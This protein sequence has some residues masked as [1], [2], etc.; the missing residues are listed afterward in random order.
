M[1]TAS[2]IAFRAY[3]RVI[4][5]LA[6]YPTLIAFAFFGLCVLSMAMEYQ[7]WVMEIKQQVDIGLVRNAENARLILG[8]LVAGIISLMVFSFSM[9]MVVLNNAAAALSPRV[10]PGLISSKGHQ[11]TLGLY[12]GT[13]LYALLLITTIERGESE[14]VP[15][16]GVLISLL[17]GIGCLAMFVHFIRSISQSI[18]VEFILNRLYRT[19]LA[20]LEQ[21]ADKLEQLEHPP[22]WPDDSRWHR[23]M[24]QRSGYFKALNITAVNALLCEHRLRMTLLVHRGFFVMAG[25][26]LFKLDRETDEAVT[27]QLLDCFDFFIEEFASSHYYFGCKQISEIAV[28]ALSPGIN[29]PATAIK[30]IDLLSVLISKRMQLA[31]LDFSPLADQ[32]PRLHHAELA[33]DPLLL[34]LFGPIRTYGASDTGVLVCLLQAFKNLLHQRPRS[35]QREALLRHAGCVI[36]AADRALA[37]T[38]D[39]E[40]INTF[41]VRINRTLDDSTMELKLLSLG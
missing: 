18:Q 26:P 28:K 25:Q 14:R 10:L 13:I 35:D 20:D 27:G 1:A 24:T 5:S 36:D 6:F 2:N 31:D 7:P 38:R 22:V 11:K 16:L 9:V 4:H 37:D 34:Q 33:L 19:T 32:P 12:L 15:S 21:R 39:R 3:Q 41:I 17:L 30:A 8:T 23:V 29:D 40:E